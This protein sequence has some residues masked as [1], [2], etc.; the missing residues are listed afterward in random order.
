[1]NN[2]NPRSVLGEAFGKL[3][4]IEVIDYIISKNAGWV[5]DKKNKKKRDL[6][7][8]FLGLENIL[9]K[10]E[11]VQLAEMTVMKKT[12][13]LPSYT[14]RYKNL[15]K[16]KDKD[17]N[18]L[19]TAFEKSYPINSVHEIVVTEIS[20]DEGKIILAVKVKEFKTSWKTDIQDLGSL[21]GVYETQ[22]IVD[23]TLGKISIE[24]G[25]DKIEEVIEAF[26]TYRLAIPL[27]PYTIGVFNAPYSQSD[28]ATEKTMLIFDFVYNRL[29]SKGISSKFNDVKFKISNVALSGGVRG[30]TL[31]GQDIINSDE[32]CKYITLGNDIV[33]FKTT[34]IYKGERL[35]ITFHLKGKEFDKLKIIIMDDKPDNFKREV[36]EQIQAEYIAMCKEG[37]KDIESTKQRLELI[38]VKFTDARGA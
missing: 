25:D 17:L 12:R 23:E 33:T 11:I 9:S 3:T 7:G 2:I 30:V 26:L 38:Y 34:S 21:T 27:I 28:S 19:K 4:R 13:G 1:M 36:M 15:G 18:E 6:E 24:V 16:L 8:D 14:Y 10:K 31:H 35:N 32:A 22:V 20:M 37:V 5:L 29:P